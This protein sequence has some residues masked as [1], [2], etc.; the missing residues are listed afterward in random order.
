M[1]QEFKSTNILQKLYNA[2]NGI[3]IPYR[4]EVSIRIQTA[5]VLAGT[6]LGFYL[7]IGRTD[8]LFLIVAAAL[9]LITECLNTALEKLVDLVSPG[10]HE[11]AGKVKDIAAGAVFLAGSA[12]LIISLLVF[13]PYFNK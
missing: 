12:A 11:I 7:H 3:L 10:Y 1:K 2:F 13:F 8:W 5:V 9:L 6:V 4:S